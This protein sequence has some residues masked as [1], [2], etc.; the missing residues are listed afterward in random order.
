MEKR[1]GILKKCVLALAVLPFLMGAAG[2]RIAG[3]KTADALYY[4]VGLYGL[5]FNS[6]AINIWIEIARWTAPFVVGAGIIAAVQRAYDYL[7]CRILC[8]YKDATA[9]YSRSE[10]GEMLKERLPHAA[11]CKDKFLN[12]FKE[13]IIMLDEDEET[14][15]FYQKHKEKFRGKKVYLCLKEIDQ[16]LLEGN[17]EAIFFNVNDVIA[18]S[19][20]KKERI[21]DRTK[22][23]EVWQAAILGFESLG[24]ELLYYGLLLNLFS[25]EQ[26]V[27]YHVFGESRLY[28]ASHCSF[29]P[30]N[31]DRVIFHGQEYYDSWEVLE[32]MD[33]IVVAAAFDIESIQALL[34]RCKKAKISYYSPKS[35]K[36]E[37][38]IGFGR[39]EAFGRDEDVYT[40]KNIKTDVTYRRAKEVHARYAFGEEGAQ[41]WQKEESF[42]KL[43][44]FTKGSNISVADYKEVV[45]KIRKEGGLA[46]TER[47][48]A[49]LEHIRW[50][51]YHFLNHWD[52]GVLPDGKLKDPV[53]KIH[54]CLCPFGRL[55][56][57]EKKKCIEVARFYEE[58][59]GEGD[60]DEKVEGGKNR[61]GRG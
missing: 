44:G 24:Q 45:Q 52:Y 9:V 30:M 41:E 11:L 57:A 61:Y 4:S 10:A 12:R 43:D 16:N 47:E 32:Q 21:W 39:L 33:H 53:Q 8:M 7:N 55:P 31:Q 18:R 59:S 29:R 40:E 46:M 2:Y 49:E 51:R 25:L 42:G 15:C 14:L 17:F 23:G 36:L 50:C 5:N 27:Y 34:C 19:F 22:G 13:H 20:W 56:E 58:E 54:S 38:F 35:G 28:Q 48:L 37:E 60:M 3:E 26:Q 6:S 1:R